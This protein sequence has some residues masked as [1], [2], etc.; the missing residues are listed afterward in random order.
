MMLSG[1][2]YCSC[3]WSYQPRGCTLW[4]YCAKMRHIEKSGPTFLY[5]SWTISQN[6]GDFF[7][8]GA[9]ILKNLVDF[10]EKVDVIFS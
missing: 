6:G 9:A 8:N 5:V 7:Q 1:E 3:Y 2:C 10:L 4:L